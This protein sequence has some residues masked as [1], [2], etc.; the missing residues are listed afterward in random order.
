MGYKELL[1]DLVKNSGLTLREIADKC[2]E[3]GISIDPSY[4]SKLQTGKQAPPSDEVSRILAEALGADPIELIWLSYTEK[5]P[6]EIKPS[7]KRLNL[8]AIQ[9]IAN[10]VGVGVE[11]IL[12]DYIEEVVR[13]KREKNRLLEKYPDKPTIEQVKMD[14]ELKSF[15]LIP[16]EMLELHLSLLYK[17]DVWASSK[18]LYTF[19]DM[20]KYPTFLSKH[21][22]KDDNKSVN[23]AKRMLSE[24]MLELYT[25][26]PNKDK[27]ELL[28]IAEMKYEHIKKRVLDMAAY[29]KKTNA[30]TQQVANVFEVSLD[31]AY[32]DMLERLPSLD[33][34]LA[35][36]VKR[37]LE[38][39]EEVI[40]N[41]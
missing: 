39:N 37:I 12:Q 13:G 35:Q 11:V 5:A 23:I 16:D 15:H 10:K 14:E 38:K 31:T 36:E 6:D 27:K 2:K 24:K 19:L 17:E 41:G 34:K 21:D 40:K 7:L 20:V 22:N 32:E 26:L 1:S 25:K 29:F 18:S 4:I 33:E 28:S 30:T 9:T 8:G 3:L